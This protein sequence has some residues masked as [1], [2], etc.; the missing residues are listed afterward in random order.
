MYDKYKK[1]LTSF[2]VNKESIYPKMNCC[3]NGNS[4]LE[5]IFNYIKSCKYPK[6]YSNKKVWLRFIIDAEEHNQ[7]I[8]IN[9]IKA[10]DENKKLK[11]N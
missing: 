11:K 3:K 7:K 1:E 9:N 5:D 8:N 2:I 4:R 10:N 6:I